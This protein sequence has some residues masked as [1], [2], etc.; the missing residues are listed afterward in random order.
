MEGRKLSHLPVVDREMRIVA[1]VAREDLSARIATATA[2]HI[3]AGTV[4]PV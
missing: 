4:T 2:D 1:L 3:E